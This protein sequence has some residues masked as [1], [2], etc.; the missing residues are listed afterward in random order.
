[1]NSLIV[2]GNSG[3]RFNEEKVLKNLKDIPGV[4]NLERRDF[5]GAVLQCEYEF[6][7]DR[8]IVRLSDDLESI[9][10]AGTGEASLHL[11]LELQRREDQPL[12]VADFGY[13]INVSLKDA[14]TIDAIKGSISASERA[15]VA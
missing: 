4:Y 8:T 10:I 6:D 11:A 1:M 3:F 12:F 15:S 13:D 9:M 2:F 5:V 7:G 14:R